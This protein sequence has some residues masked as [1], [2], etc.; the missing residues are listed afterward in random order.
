[1]DTTDPLTEPRPS[2]PSVE[3]EELEPLPKRSAT[4]I[5]SLLVFGPR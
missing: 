5:L 4:V 2:E 3:S 1:M